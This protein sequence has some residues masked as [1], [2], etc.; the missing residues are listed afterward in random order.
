M[1]LDMQELLEKKFLANFTSKVFSQHILSAAIG[2]I[3][4][5]DRN[6]DTTYRGRMRRTTYDLEQSRNYN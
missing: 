5:L 6:D 4:C 2:Q 1:L 3:I